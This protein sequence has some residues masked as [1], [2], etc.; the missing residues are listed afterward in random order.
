M[1]S[2][3]CDSEALQEAL[4]HYRHAAERTRN[5]L[6]ALQQYVRELEQDE[7]TRGLESVKRGGELTEL[8]GQ[9]AGAMTET[10][11]GGVLEALGKVVA[12][13]AQEAIDDMRAGNLEANRA[14]H[15]RILEEDLRLDLEEEIEARDKARALLDAYWE[16][17]ERMAPRRIRL[18]LT[19]QAEGGFLGITARAEMGLSG[20]AELVCVDPCGSSLERLQRWMQDP[21]LSERYGAKGELTFTIPLYEWTSSGSEVRATQV[22]HEESGGALTFDAVIRWFRGRPASVDL[23]RITPLGTLNQHVQ[24]EIM[25]F[26]QGKSFSSDQDLVPVASRAFMAHVGTAEPR[27]RMCAEPPSPWHGSDELP[28]AWGRSALDV[29]ITR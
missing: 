16:C 19:M 28:Q 14:E 8:A 18:A 4:R 2:S 20:E 9:I 23:F 29:T 21:E 1:P 11:P 3:E 17:T 26:G 10:S 12:M 13:A 7:A 22:T 5:Q 27:V 6:A 25:V 15:L 24:G